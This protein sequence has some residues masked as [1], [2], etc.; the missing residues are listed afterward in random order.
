MK[1]EDNN[2]ENYIVPL[3][4]RVSACILTVLGW[5]TSGILP[6]FF[7]RIVQASRKREEY[8]KDF[9]YLT[10]RQ[11][12]MMQL[13]LG[14]I[15]AIMIFVV[16]TGYEYISGET[17]HHITIS[18]Q[19]HLYCYVVWRAAVSIIAGVGSAMAMLGYVFEY[20]FVEWFMTKIR[21]INFVDG[22][23]EEED[24]ENND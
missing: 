14:C 18:G 8:E 22:R 12:C 13:V 17:L 19:S 1:E 6:L 21:L 7:I 16:G 2:K 4:A 10:A 9:V 15:V 11:S 3:R 24:K 23:K 5:I 20:P